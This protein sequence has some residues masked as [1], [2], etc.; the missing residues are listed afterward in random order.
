MG[1]TRLNARHGQTILTWLIYVDGVYNCTL[2]NNSGSY[3][4]KFYYFVGT[5]HWYGGTNPTGQQIEMYNMTTY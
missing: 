2:T 5:N 3:Y 1:T 4:N